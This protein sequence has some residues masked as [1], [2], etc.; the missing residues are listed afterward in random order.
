MPAPTAKQSMVQQEEL[1]SWIYS[2][3]SDLTSVQY[4]EA[5]GT[6]TPVGDPIEANS[7]SNVIAKA[8]P[9]GSETLIIGSVKSNIGHTES[10][11]GVAGL[12]KVLLMMKHETIVASVFL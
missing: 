6:G 12:I 7:I 1:L 3:E 5:H 4:I 2:T 10:A 11:A 9:P 8:R